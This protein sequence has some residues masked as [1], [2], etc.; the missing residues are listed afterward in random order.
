MSPDSNGEPAMRRASVFGILA[1]VAFLALTLIAFFEPSAFA[2]VRLRASENAL[3]L[4]LSLATAAIGAKLTLAVPAFG[5]NLHVSTPLLLT[6]A[7]PYLLR[8]ALWKSGAWKIVWRRWRRS[9]A[10]AGE[11]KA[12]KPGYPPGV[13]AALPPRVAVALAAAARAR[14]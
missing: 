10:P 13:P 3:C 11:T 8:S 5:T 14:A 2:L 12:A 6:L 1:L 4:L 9:A 7:A